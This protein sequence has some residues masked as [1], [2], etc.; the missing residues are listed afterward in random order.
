MLGVSHGDAEND[1]PLIGAELTVVRHGITGD[2]WG[3]DDLL[4]LSAIE[5]TGDLV[6]AGQVRG[7]L[8]RVVDRLGQESVV[9]EPL[10]GRPHDHAV[11]HGSK[12]LAIQALRGCRDADELGV[13]PAGE[14]FHVGLGDRVMRLVDDDEVRSGDLIQSPAESLDRGDHGRLLGHGFPGLDEPVRDRDLG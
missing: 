4:G 13:W 2:A 14:H 1:S 9:D 6:Y 3:V 7:V 11:E 8:G 10:N 12:A 5:V